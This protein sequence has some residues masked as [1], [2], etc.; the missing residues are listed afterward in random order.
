LHHL[1]CILCLLFTLVIKSGT[2]EI[3]VALLLAEISNPFNLFRENLKLQGLENTP[4]FKLIGIW[5]CVI[6]IVSRFMILPPYFM[7]FLP[8][9]SNFFIKFLAVTTWFVSWHWLF[10]IINMLIKNFV[11]SQKE[12]ITENSTVFCKLLQKIASLRK[13]QNFLRS[14]YVFITLVCYGPLVI[15]A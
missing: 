10:I 14:Y 1:A 12:K 6:F 8:S 4:R 11:P 13:N 9:A 15:Y 2:N 3:L 5:F 7:Y